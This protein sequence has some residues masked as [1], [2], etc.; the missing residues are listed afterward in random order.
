MGGNLV[1]AL[2]GVASAQLVTSPLIA[3][4][5]SASGAPHFVFVPGSVRLLVYAP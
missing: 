2:I 4:A 3:A 5:P 1:A